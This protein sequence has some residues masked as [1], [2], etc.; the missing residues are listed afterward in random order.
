VRFIHYDEARKAAM[1]RVRAHLAATPGIERLLIVND[2]FG[3]LRVVVW[4]AEDVFDDT[5]RELSGQLA[6]GCGPWWTGELLSVGGAGT[7]ATLWE[8]AWHEASR[9]PDSERLRRLDRHR[10]RTAWFADADAPVW[11]APEEGPPVVVFYSFKGGMGRSTTLASFAVQRAQAGERVAVVD[12]DLDAPGIGTLLAV[13]R[14]GVIAPWGVVD[15]LLERPRGEVPLADYNHSC[16]RLAA[17]GEIRVFPAGNLDDSYAEKLARVDFDEPTRSARSTY[18]QLLEDIRATLSPRWILLDARTG[19]SEPAGRLLSG[20]AH[21]HVLFA[22]TS[23]QSWRGLRAV[24]DRLGSHRVLARRTQAEIVLVQAMVPSTTEG[25]RLAT[26][27]FAERAR[28]EFTDHYYAAE[29]S[30]PEDDRFW[31]VGDLDSEDAP[32]VPLAIPYRESLAHFA[33]IADIVDRLAERE[34]AAIA[35]RIAE[36]FRPT[37]A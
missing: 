25:A 34:Y 29:P 2:I 1:D 33:D 20:L 9:D 35:E 28:Q 22:T 16:S 15:Y 5:R 7:G 26:A 30:E 12:F 24:L 27:S 19:M 31:D 21:L 3:S 13:D 23:E 6:E 37:E 17:A 18:V 32:H 10:S 4:A 8:E 11:R 36:R 14:A